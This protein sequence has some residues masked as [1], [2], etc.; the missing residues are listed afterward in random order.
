[1]VAWDRDCMRGGG[2]VAWDRDCMRGGGVVAWDRDCMRGGGVVAWD[3]DCMR[4]GRGCGC[5][6]QGLHERGE[7]VWLP[8]TG[9]A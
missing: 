8:G 4:E 1:M 5:L 2:V 7:G 9:T 6:G 3:R